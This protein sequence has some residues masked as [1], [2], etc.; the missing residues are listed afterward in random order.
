[1]LLSVNCAECSKQAHYAECRY[2]ECHY[3]ECRGVTNLLFL[4]KKILD[5]NKKIYK[6]KTQQLITAAAKKFDRIE[7]WG[8]YHKTYY[9]RKLR[10]P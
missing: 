3:A 2:A 9:G 5:L 8:L 4:I 7:P 1:M 10:F 6:Y